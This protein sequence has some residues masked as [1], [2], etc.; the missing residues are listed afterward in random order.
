M[1]KAAKIDDNQP[2]IVEALEKAGC[3][4]QSLAAVGKG[5]PDLLV[6]RAGVNYVLE[7]KD[8]SKSPS[9]RR[10]TSDQFTWSMAWRGEFAVV[11]SVD[12]ALEA[13]GL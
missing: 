13:V 11:C 7:V 4:V 2:E 3:S 12:E 8:G 5:V 1:R 9:R 10:L 6:G